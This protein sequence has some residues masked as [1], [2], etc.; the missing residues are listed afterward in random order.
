MN[1][2]YDKLRAIYRD[3]ARLAARDWKYGYDLLPDEIAILDANLHGGP[4]LDAGCGVG[5]SFSYFEQRKIKVIG[6]DAVPEMLERAAEQAPLAELVRGELSQVGALFSEDR[7]A[8]VI[9]LGNTVGG[10][11]TDDERRAFFAGVARVLKPGGVFAVDCVYGDI[12]I[13]MNSGGE[14]V[15]DNRSR[16]GGFGYIFTEELAGRKIPCYQYYFSEAEFTRHL[17]GA[18]FRFDLAEIDWGAFRLN[19]AICRPE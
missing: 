9:C 12:E 14:I 3:Y 18:G 6:L 11:I 7:F 19:V 5:R 4:V 16:G 1:V 10:L 13:A 15:I 2:D 8:A 17:A